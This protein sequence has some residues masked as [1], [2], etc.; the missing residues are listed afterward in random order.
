[1]TAE[2]AYLSTAVIDGVEQ[3]RL[4]SHTTILGLGGDTPRPGRPVPAETRLPEEI[5]LTC[6]SSTVDALQP[7]SVLLHGDACGDGG[8]PPRWLPARKSSVVVQECSFESVGGGLEFES[9]AFAASPGVEW[10]FENSDCAAQEGAFR[11]IA[12]DPTGARAR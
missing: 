3:F 12:P 1:M 9:A 10:A 5:R 8:A 2:G 4:M 6:R 7:G 11:R